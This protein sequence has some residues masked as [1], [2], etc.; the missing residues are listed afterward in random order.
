MSQK[1]VGKF[2]LSPYEAR[3]QASEAPAGPVPTI[4][5]SVV[6]DDTDASFGSGIEELLNSA[7]FM[8]AITGGKISEPT[9]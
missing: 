2:Y 4:N 8:D 5:T 7:L 3:K 6:T 9:I 1:K